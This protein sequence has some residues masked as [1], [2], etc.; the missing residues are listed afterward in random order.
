MVGHLK[1][2]CLHTQ[3]F[4]QYTMHLAFFGRGRGRRLARGRG[5]RARQQCLAGPAC[6]CRL[7][8]WRS[9]KSIDPSVEHWSLSWLL[10]LGA[11][12]LGKAVVSRHDGLFSLNSCNPKTS[13]NHNIHSIK[14]VIVKKGS[15]L[16]HIGN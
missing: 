11:L 5:Y 8:L 9:S 15:T 7:H 12:E 4:V 14:H 1:V 6:R 10:L 3:Y 2:D 13:F 16:I